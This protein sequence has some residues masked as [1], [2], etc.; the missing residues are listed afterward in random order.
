M[1]L[2]VNEY[3]CEWFKLALFWEPFLF[4]LFMSV[5]IA[6]CDVHVQFIFKQ[7]MESSLAIFSVKGILKCE[8]MF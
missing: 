1:E 7:V 3:Q 5:L 6:S 2:S 4:V 8:R